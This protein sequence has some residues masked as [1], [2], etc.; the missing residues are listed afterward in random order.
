MVLGKLTKRSFKRNGLSRRAKL[1]Q[2]AVTKVFRP[3]V[4]HEFRE[5]QERYSGRPRPCRRY[6]LAMEIGGYGIGHVGREFI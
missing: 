4:E 2:F 5:N 1:A 3:K 6:C